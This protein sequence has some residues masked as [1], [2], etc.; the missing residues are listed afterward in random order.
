MIKNYTNE[1]RDTLDEL[2]KHDVVLISDWV[3][4]EYVYD[5]IHN[6]PADVYQIEK[7]IDAFNKYKKYYLDYY[8]SDKVVLVKIRY[9]S[10]NK[11]KTLLYVCDD[12]QDQLYLDYNKGDELNDDSDLWVK[13]KSTDHF[14][15]LDY[16][17]VNKET[18]KYNI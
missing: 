3:K 6:N 5:V 2:N 1:F 11:S 15:V 14:E 13:F 8:E 10:M 4:T 7:S 18:D 16:C 12:F 9:N 17:R